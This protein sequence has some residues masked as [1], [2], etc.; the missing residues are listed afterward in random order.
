MYRTKLKQILLTQKVV[1][2]NVNCVG[3]EKVGV[4]DHILSTTHFLRSLK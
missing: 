1:M 2:Y 3:V 4:Y